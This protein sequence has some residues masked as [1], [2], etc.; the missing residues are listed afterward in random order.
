MDRLPDAVRG[1]VHT[2]ASTSRRLTAR[3]AKSELGLQIWKMGDEVFFSNR[4]LYARI[5]YAMQPKRARPGCFLYHTS[6]ARRKHFLCVSPT[7]GIS[8]F[9]LFCLGF[10]PIR[11]N[12]LIAL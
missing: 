8:H 4:R 2:Q 11:P 12:L 1:N 9:L 5:R 6:I 10:A 3:C 7:M